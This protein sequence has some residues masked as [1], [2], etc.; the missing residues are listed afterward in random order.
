M[1]NK[2]GRPKALFSSRL[3]TW[4]WYCAVKE[5]TGLKDARLDVKYCR[6]LGSPPATRQDYLTRVKAFEIIRLKGGEI[7]RINSGTK[8]LSKRTFDLPN[9]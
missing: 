7:T 1:V 4:F 5:I 2:T 6:P 9:A 8:S 3:K